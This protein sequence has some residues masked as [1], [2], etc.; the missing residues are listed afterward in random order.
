[1]TACV[2]DSYLKNNRA[3]MH[4]RDYIQSSWAR[5]YMG[6]VNPLFLDF[7]G[8]TGAAFITL[9]ELYFPFKSIS[10]AILC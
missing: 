6:A 10:V 7:I 9:E 5:V 2:K 1:M 3:E 8:K 4:R